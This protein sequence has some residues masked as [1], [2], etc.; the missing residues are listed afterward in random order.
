MKVSVVVYNVADCNTG[1]VN[2]QGKVRFPFK[3]CCFYTMSLLKEKG[4]QKN[5]IKLIRLFIFF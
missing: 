3:T 5:P 1:E 4:K 2:V